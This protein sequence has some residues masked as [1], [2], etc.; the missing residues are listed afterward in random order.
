MKNLEA[1]VEERACVNYTVQYAGN[2]EFIF[3][4]KKRKSKCDLSEEMK[5][6]IEIFIDF[7]MYKEP[8]ESILFVDDGVS[9]IPDTECIRFYF[10]EEYK[11]LKKD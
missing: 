5:E 3:L 8:E 9:P 2:G 4:P 11:I 10:E 6:L 1:I 7:T